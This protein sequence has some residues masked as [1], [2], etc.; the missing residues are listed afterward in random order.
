MCAKD[1]RSSNAFASKFAVEVTAMAMNVNAVSTDKPE[2]GCWHPPKW[3][4]VL[5]T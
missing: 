1:Q 4:Y 5:G 3:E 2:G